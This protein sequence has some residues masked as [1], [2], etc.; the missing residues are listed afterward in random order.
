[1][2]D[3]K[4]PKANPK[5]LSDFKPLESNATSLSQLANSTALLNFPS[6][7]TRQIVSEL[8]NGNRGTLSD[9]RSRGAN[10]LRMS[11]LENNRA[12]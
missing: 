7:L 3:F 2:S 10:V 9:E 12:E 6:A 1:M 11:R 4:S 5:P 8:E